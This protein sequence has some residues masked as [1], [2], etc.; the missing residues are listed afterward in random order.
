MKNKYF[1]ITRTNLYSY[2]VFDDRLMLYNKK[3]TYEV[4]NSGKWFSYINVDVGRKNH[5]GFDLPESS[6]YEKVRP[7]LESDFN[8]LF[9]RAFSILG[10]FPVDSG[11]CYLVRNSD[12]S[13][14]LYVFVEDDKGKN[15]RCCSID[16][17]DFVDSISCRVMCDTSFSNRPSVRKKGIPIEKHLFVRV[18][19]LTLDY[20]RDP[21]SCNVLLENYI[22]NF[23]N[24]V[25]DEE[26][27][28]ELI[29]TTRSDLSSV[30]KI[31]E[32]RRNALLHNLIELDETREQR[33]QL[34]AE[35]AGLEFAL[36]VLSQSTDSQ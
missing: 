36:Q 12:N 22:R 7:V 30:I 13:F 26:A 17:R 21:D 32:S 23:K 31:I 34:R 19:K 33:V 15:R 8:R 4:I 20:V 3:F 6:E 18:L 11:E 25:T 14:E 28:A 9:N 27:D 29:L 5:E 35:V 24:L 2:S 1:R 10:S 16:V